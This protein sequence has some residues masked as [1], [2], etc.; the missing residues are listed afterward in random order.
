MS[1]TTITNRK[2]AFQ[3]IR[4][5]IANNKVRDFSDIYRFMYDN[6][7]DFAKGKEAEVIVILADSQYRD[8]MVID[9]E[10]TFMSCV[11]QI[12]NTL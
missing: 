12:L 6:L 1:P 9:H 3:A 11:V 10:I 7:D 2:T 5:A 8:S 4:K